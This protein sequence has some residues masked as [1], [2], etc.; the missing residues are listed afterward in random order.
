IRTSGLDFS[1]Q[2]KKIHKRALSNF[3]FESSGEKIITS[4]SSSKY[5]APLKTPK[6][7]KNIYIFFF[8][9]DS[10]CESPK[11]R[12]S[13][14]KITNGRVMVS[15]QLIHNAHSKQQSAGN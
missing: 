14:L 5:I 9:P 3:R 11:R 15:R 12:S 10:E 8:S 7:R 13:I 6:A 4:I 2:G 1:P